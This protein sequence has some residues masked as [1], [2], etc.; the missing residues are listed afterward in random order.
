MH[1]RSFFSSRWSRRLLYLA[2]A[3]VFIAAATWKAVPW[4]TRHAFDQVPEYLPGFKTGAE[5]VLFNPF[6]LRLTL[7]GLSVSHERLG[8]IVS[9]KEISAAVNPASIFRLAAGLRELKVTGPKITLGI[10]ADGGSILDVLPKSPES[11]AEPPKPV[12][13]PRVIVGVFEVSDGEL[14][15]ESRLR[16]A[17]QR[18]MVKPIQ[19]RLENLSTLP[20]D[21]GRHRMQARTN[22]G[23]RMGWEGELTVQPLRL[24]GRVEF[25][26]VDLTRVSTAAPTLPIEIAQGRLDASTEYEV[27]LD[28]GAVTASLKNARTTIRDL[29]WR[30]KGSTEPLRGP[31]ALDI[32]P[33]S[34]SAATP[35]GRITLRAD[36][37]VQSSGTV[38][39]RAYLTPKPLA[40]GADF[41]VESLPLAPFSPLAPPPLQVSLDG[42]TFDARGKASISGSDVDAEV[43]LSVADVTVSEGTSGR[44]LAKLGKLAVESAK[45]STKD[46]RAEVAA[47]RIERPFLRLARGTDSRTNIENALGISLSTGAAAAPVQTSAPP[48]PQGPPWRVRL[49]RFSVLKGRIVA[50]DDAVAPSFAFAVSEARLE[51]TGLSNDGRST[52]TFATSALVERSSFSADGTVRLSTRAAWVEARLKADAIQLPVFSPYS[53]QVIGYKIDKGAMSFDLDE[54]LADRAITTRNHVIIDQM[55]LGEKVE[56]PTAIKAPVKL[57]LAILK[58]RRGVIDLDV[59]IDGS[60]DDPEFHIG[61]VILKTLVNLIAKAALSPFAALG[62]MMGSKGDLGQVAFPAGEAAVTSEIADQLA[63]VAQALT[64]RPEMSLGIRGIAGRSDAVAFGDK[65]LLRRLRGPEA[66]NAPLTPQEEKRVLAF[67]REAFGADAPSA[68]QA[69]V[70]LAEKS[71]ASDADLRSLALSRVSSIKDV[72]VSRGLAESRFFS[73]DPSAGADAADEPCRLELDVR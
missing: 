63:K 8:E 11:P 44:P 65:A 18:L 33:A 59:P 10:G 9:C 34:V 64:D 5:E 71:R 46:R 41:E 62:Q 56:S 23:E 36:V 15:F 47:V 39:V 19:F 1:I 24:Q 66:D 31:F 61:R 14:N 72:L 48:T 52:A 60:L 4:A 21:N 29:S 22:R 45:A 42:G 35:G 40:G 27:A 6:S 67:Y 37:P 68:A 69:R 53:V 2:G 28:S 58:D 32:G 55:T 30:L 49:K 38:R 70:E 51:L 20:D 13:I 7:S 25:N 57:G 50:Q 43:S 54:R 16:S 12:F 26:S 3:Y 17:P 73:L